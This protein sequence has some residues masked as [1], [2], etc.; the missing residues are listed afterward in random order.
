VSDPPLEIFGRFV[1]S[2][3]VENIPQVTLSSGNVAGC[4]LVTDGK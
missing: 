1:E 2:L 3:G 4:Y